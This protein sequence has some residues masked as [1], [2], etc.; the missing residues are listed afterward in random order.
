MD[1]WTL[2]TMG[3][4]AVVFVGALVGIYAGIRRMQGHPGR[5][6]RYFETVA[7]GTSAGV[8]PT[9]LRGDPNP[10]VQEDVEVSRGDRAS[11]ETP[12]TRR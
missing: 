2:I 12:G 6:D 10:Q 4:G 1:V 9:S 7:R 11:R 8:Y 3:M 5:F